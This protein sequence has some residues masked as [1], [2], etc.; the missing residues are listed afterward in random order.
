MTAARINDSFA[1]LS[2]GDGIDP[3][4]TQDASMRFPFSPPARP[5]R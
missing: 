4:F 5:G 3:H 2:A 1:V